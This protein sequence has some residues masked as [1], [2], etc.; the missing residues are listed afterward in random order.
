MKT[1]NGM[2]V[3]AHRAKPNNAGFVVL[4]AAESKELGYEYVTAC[5]DS[6]TDKEWYWGHYFTD[7]SSAVYDF[8]LRG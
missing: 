4:L 8:K 3:I 2:A 1:I 7:L 6:L 5:V